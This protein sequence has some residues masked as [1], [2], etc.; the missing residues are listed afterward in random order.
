MGVNEAGD[1]ILLLS[2][3]SGR[4]VG[5]LEAALVRAA[6]EGPWAFS[7]GVVTNR[8]QEEQANEVIREKAFQFLNQV[9][10]GREDEEQEI[11]YEIIFVHEGW[12][13]EK[14]VL[15]ALET[16]QVQSPSQ[17]RIVTRAKWR[18]EQAAAKDLSELFGRPIGVKIAVAVEKS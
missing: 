5:Q 8:S 13:K 15:T 11:P 18:I 14:G 12:R 7:P 2:A 10:V 17:Q 16:L 9:G 6:Y 1:Q 3:L 4:G